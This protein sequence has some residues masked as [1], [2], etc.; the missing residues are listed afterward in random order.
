MNLMVSYHQNAATG[1][2]T[3][4]QKKYST[5]RFGYAAREEPAVFLV[6]AHHAQ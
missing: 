6:D 2:L 1:K 3:A 5:S 4:V